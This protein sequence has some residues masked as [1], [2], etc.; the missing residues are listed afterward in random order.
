M[1]DTFNIYY[2]T[3][4]TK[5]Y[6]NLSKIIGES[7]RRFEYSIMAAES[8]LHDCRHKPFPVADM[9]GITDGYLGGRINVTQLPFLAHLQMKQ[10][11]TNR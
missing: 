5:C 6:S 8:T 11:K 7:I 4:D 2:P 1:R 3:T 9:D 10:Q